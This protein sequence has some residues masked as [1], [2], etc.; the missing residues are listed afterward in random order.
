MTWNST[1]LANGYFAGPRV[2]RGPTPRWCARRSVDG[3]QET[4]P[5]VR[6]MRRR[7]NTHGGH[8]SAADTHNQTVDH[9]GTN[10][11]GET[12][13]GT[14][15]E[16]FYVPS[17]ALVFWNCIFFFVCLWPLFRLIQFSKMFTPYVYLFIYRMALHLTLTTNKIKL[18][19]N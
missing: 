6:E 9:F 13:T 11:D 2:H 3:R 15:A 5:G 4:R 19:H 16:G 8:V 14:Y 10:K 17:K 18:I 12:R 7:Q 1:V